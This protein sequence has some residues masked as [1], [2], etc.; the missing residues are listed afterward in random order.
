M[1]YQTKSAAIANIIMNENRVDAFEAVRPTLLQWRMNLR[2]LK[3]SSLQGSSAMFFAGAGQVLIREEREVGSEASL[4]AVHNP[5][6]HSAGFLEVKALTRPAYS[7]RIFLLTK[8]PSVIAE[9]QQGGEMYRRQFGTELWH[10]SP[11][12]EF[13]PQSNY[14]EMEY[15]SIGKLCSACEQRGNRAR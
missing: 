11:E 13:W 1:K 4:H 2:S 3:P 9:F 7:G 8:A 12:C 10:S 5:V 14:D 6:L 15:P